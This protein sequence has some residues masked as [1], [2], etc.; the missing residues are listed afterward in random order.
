MESERWFERGE[1][2]ERETGKTEMLTNN[3]LGAGALLIAGLKLVHFR[4]EFF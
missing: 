2:R 1:K 3:G 4:K